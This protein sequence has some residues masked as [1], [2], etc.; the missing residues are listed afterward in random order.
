MSAET[1]RD[2]AEIARRPKLVEI[3][4]NRTHVGVPQHVTGAEIVAAAG[5]PSNFELRRV[6]GRRE[7]PVEDDD[8][9]TVHEGERF[10]ASP[11]LDYSFIS[12]VAHAEAVESVRVQFPEHAVDVEEPGDGTTHVIVRGVEIGDGWNTPTIDLEVR[13]APAFPSTVPYPFYGPAGLARTDGQA[14]SPIQPE[15]QLDSQ[16]RTQISL[17]KEFDP[18]NET[19]GA[20]LSWVASWLESPR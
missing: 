13:L 14:L 18:T 9:I 4:V 16:L 11:A 12:N 2:A 10:V 6:Q 19:L 3:V 17:R 1:H 5:L 20:R 7:I 8:R 15:V